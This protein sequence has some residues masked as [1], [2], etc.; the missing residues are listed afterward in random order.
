MVVALLVAQSVQGLG[1]LYPDLINQALGGHRLQVP[2]D[3]RQR[4]RVVGL[5]EL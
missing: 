5:H 4:N 3:G 1:A 2:V